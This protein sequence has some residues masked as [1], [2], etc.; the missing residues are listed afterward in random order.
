MKLN[1]LPRYG[2]TYQRATMLQH[3]GI[4]SEEAGL[5]HTFYRQESDNLKSV[6]F[7]VQR[8]SAAK[9]VGGR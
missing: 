8:N 5:K 7:G 3:M 1:L 2:V 9:T 6:M 4:A